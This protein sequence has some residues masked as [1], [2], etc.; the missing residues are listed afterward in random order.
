MKNWKQ[1]RAYNISNQLFDEF[2]GRFR[3]L[4]GARLHGVTVGEAHR[5]GGD[6]RPRSGLCRLS[7]SHRHYARIHFLVV[8]LLHDVDD[9]RTRQLRMEQINPI[10]I[11]NVMK[12]T[13]VRAHSL[14]DRKP[15]LRRWAT[16]TQSSAGIA[17]SSSAVY[18]ASTLSSDW[19]PA[20]R[21]RESNTAAHQLTNNIALIRIPL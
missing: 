13:L 12:W 2:S 10:P 8:A 7:R 3:H 11:R 19:L 17:K 16:N 4:L 21:Q 15:S 6:R 1:G 20:P 14:A 5:P 9:T 18:L